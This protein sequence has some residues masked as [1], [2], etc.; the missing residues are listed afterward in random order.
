[1][2]RAFRT[3]W[4]G[5]ESIVAAETRGQAAAKT[6]AAAKEAGYRV[7][8]SWK[9]LRVVRAPEHDAWAELDCTGVCW[10]EENL[11]KAVPSC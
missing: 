7:G 9:G 6:M 8:N 10:A 5:V 1:M 11:P 2:K 3:S 4:G